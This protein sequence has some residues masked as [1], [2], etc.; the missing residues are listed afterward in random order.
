MSWLSSFFKPAA[1]RVDAARARELVAQGAL[2]IDVRTPSEFAQGSV[3]GA[4]N[5]PLQAVQASQHD[6]APDQTYVL[7]CL[8]GG[9][10][11]TAGKALKGQGFENLYD[12]GSWK[13]W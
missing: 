9:R 2:L 7:F 4:R 12:L 3:P 8:S 5:V 11:A 13:N 6:L 10:S 1:T